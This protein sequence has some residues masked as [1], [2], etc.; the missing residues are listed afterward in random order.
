MRTSIKIVSWIII[1][2]ILFASGYIT[3]ITQYNKK[4]GNLGTIKAVGVNIFTDSSM[5]TPDRKSVV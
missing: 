2:L 5:R 1:A 4:F 3:A